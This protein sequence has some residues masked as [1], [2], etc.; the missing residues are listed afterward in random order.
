MLEPQGPDGGRTA[1][2]PTATKPTGTTDPTGA[3]QDPKKTE[4]T[5]E[6]TG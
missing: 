2:K 1:E 3:T 6:K 4:K 5:G